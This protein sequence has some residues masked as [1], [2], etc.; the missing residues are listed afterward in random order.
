MPQLSSAF[1]QGRQLA[2]AGPSARPSLPTRHQTVIRNIFGNKQ[3][4][5]SITKSTTGKKAPK[6]FETQSPA[7]AFTRKREIIAGRAAMSGFISALIGEWLT[8]KG[9]LGQLQLE[10]KLPPNVIDLLT[11][12]LVGFNFLTALGPGSPTFSESNQRDVKKRGAGPVQNPSGVSLTQN[13]KRFFG[14]DES[15][16]GFTKKNELFVGRVAMLGFASELVGEKLSGGK[17]P[18]GQLGFPVQG[19]AAGYEVVALGIWV[20]FFLVAAVGYGNFGQQEGGD[21]VF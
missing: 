14:I 11:L 3:K 12:G 20:G 18:L 9:A 2:P 8:G 19:Q 10:T 21:D 4:Q 17:G 16:F 13:P 15:G 1:V 6:G 5:P 7:S